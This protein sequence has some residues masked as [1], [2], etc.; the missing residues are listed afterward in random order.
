MLNSVS[1]IGRLTKT[2]TLQTT[3]NDKIF[4]RFTLAIR[5]VYKNSDGDYDNNFIQCIFW[6]SSAKQLVK[7]CEKGDTIAVWGALDT[8]SYQ[9]KNGETVYQTTVII[10]DFRTVLSKKDEPSE[11]PYTPTYGSLEEELASIT[12]GPPQPFTDD[13]YPW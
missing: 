11:H 2:P 3:K 5:K 8:D 1:L 9:N 4:C 10:S 12:P 7:Q 6:G 13:D